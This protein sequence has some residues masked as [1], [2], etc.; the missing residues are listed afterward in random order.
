MELALFSRQ[1]V[2]CAPQLLQQDSALLQGRVLDSGSVCL[3]AML[4]DFSDG[5]SQRLALHDVGRWPGRLQALWSGVWNTP[6]VIIDGTKHVGLDAARKAIA[7]LAV[8]SRAVD[9]VPQAG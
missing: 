3:L 4:G 1:H 8:E 2:A 6:A 9:P 7:A 5:T